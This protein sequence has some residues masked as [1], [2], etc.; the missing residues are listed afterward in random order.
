MA[1]FEFCTDMLPNIN[2]FVLLDLFNL[3][4]VSL[5]DFFSPANPLYRCRR[6][7]DVWAVDKFADDPERNDRKIDDKYSLN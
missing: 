2:L 6:L 5:K 4:V 7:H 1:E 3:A